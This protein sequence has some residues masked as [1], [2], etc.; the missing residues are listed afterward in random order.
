MP[1]DR[2]VTERLRIEAARR[3]LDP[4]LAR[5]VAWIESHG[6][7]DARGAAG[8]IGVM[9]LMPATA[10]ELKVNAYDIQEN[11]EGGVR[12]LSQLVGKYGVEAGVAA[13]NAGASRI[14]GRASTD[15]PRIT[16]EYV[17]A[18]LVQRAA[19]R[20]TLDAQ[21]ARTAEV[22]LAQHHPPHQRHARR[23]ARAHEPSRA[24]LDPRRRQP[25]ERRHAAPSTQVLE[26]SP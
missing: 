18:V 21:G 9:Q 10:A 3:G 6:N 11:I 19:E 17:R 23:A 1:M 26:W 2:Y 16:Q 8:E 20:R 13:Y 22:P 12:Y 15:W 25:R 7:Q 4:A 24:Q 14:D 5:A